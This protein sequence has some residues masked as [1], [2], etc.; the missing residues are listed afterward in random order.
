MLVVWVLGFVLCCVKML[1]VVF[2]CVSRC[3][4]LSSCFC[5][6]FFEVV[7]IASNYLRLL[8]VPFGCVSCVGWFRFVIG[9]CGCLNLFL[10][11]F[12]KRLS[13]F[14]LL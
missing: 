8:E 14:S 3:L 5:F 1:K 12:F 7:Q 6:F 13:G 4:F 10:S 9:K 2:F 11:C